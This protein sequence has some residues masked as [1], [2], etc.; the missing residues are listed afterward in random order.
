MTEN[1]IE[2][3]D[4]KKY[5]PIK[6]GIFSRTVEQVKAVDGV[7][8]SIKKGETLGLVGESGCGKTTVGRS[9]LRLIEPDSGEIIFEDKDIMK[10]GRS[11]LRHIRPNMQIVFQDPNSSLDPRMSVKDIIGEPMVVNK[12]NGADMEDKIGKLLKAVGLNPVD[13]Y[14]YPHEFSGGQRQR[15]CIARALALNPKFIVLDEPT[16]ALDVSVQSQILNMLEDLQKEFGL[17]YLFIS[18]NLI[19]VKYLSDR[20]AVMYLGK[21]VELAKTEALFDSPM[22][23]YTQALLSAIAVP[24]PAVKRSQRIILEGDVPTPINPPKG[25]R[26]HTRCRYKMDICDKVEPEFKDIGGE[27]FVACHL[28]DKR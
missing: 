20:V 2:V 26:F 10:Y 15:I 25:C 14:R 8:L 18:H 6:G 17:T 5:F 19:V 11:E 9:I 3:N 4:L 12:K 21:V 27:H 23:P 1:L 7:S 22:H 16:S 24:D 28:M 13:M